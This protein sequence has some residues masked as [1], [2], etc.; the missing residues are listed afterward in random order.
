VIGLACDRVVTDN[1]RETL[2]FGSPARLPSGPVEMARRTGAPLLPACALR[3]P[4][5]SFRV[6]IEAPIEVEASADPQADL[7]A[8]M[9]R[10]V[11]VMEGWIAA[12]PEQWLISVPVWQQAAPA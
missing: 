1:A 10:L 7:A 11:A 5:E 8:G 4:D 6:Q 2:F 12:H 3:L 9:Q